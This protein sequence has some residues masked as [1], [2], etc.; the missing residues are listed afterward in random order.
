MARPVSEETERKKTEES[1]KNA[2]KQ[3]GL[4]EKFLEDKVREYMSFYDDLTHI[5]KTGRKRHFKKLYRCHGREAEDICRD[6]EHPEIPGVEAGRYKPGA[7]R[8]CG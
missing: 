3:N 5:N 2:L 4:S 1:L 7:G 6:A 8:R